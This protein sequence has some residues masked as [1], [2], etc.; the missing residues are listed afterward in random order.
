MKNDTTSRRVL[1]AGG[2]GYGNVGDEAQC[3]QILKELTERFPDCQIINLTPNIE[4][5]SKQHP[6]YQHELA[7]RTAFFKQNRKG[8]CFNFGTSF[9][10][11]CK[12]ILKSCW[13]YINAKLMQHK[14]PSILLDDDSVKLLRELKDASLFYFCGGGY[15]TGMTQSRL[16]DGALVCRLCHLFKTPVVMSGQTIGVWS[17]KWN[18]RIAKWGFKHVRVITARDEVHTLAA[19]K[20]IGLEGDS[21]F[22]T[23]DDAL[24]CEK[25]CDRQVA[26]QSYITLN[27]HYWGMS[28]EQRHLCIDKIHRL[29]EYVLTQT[30]DD[31]VF[32]P[33]VASDEQS[34]LDYIKKYPNERLSCFH[35]DYDFRK[36]RRVIADSNMCLTMKHHP[37]IFAMGEDCPA[38]SLAFSEYYVHKNVGALCQYKQ[39][40]FSVNMEQ[41][42]WFDDFAILFN[43][44]LSH[45]DEM[46]LLIKQQKQVLKQRKE[47]LSDVIVSILN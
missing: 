20:S 35:Y 7:S 25:S 46:K 12:F 27:F 3:N 42:S 5:S 13:V 34:Y 44:M 26:S 1:V 43:R 21:Y 30:S 37:I 22:A 24:F 32:I 39:E 38:L 18:Q 9:K 23:H 16:W 11:R 6:Q 15:L 45:S 31:L 28:G 8:D 41:E 29:V 33:M 40:D 36:V 14:L 10:R 2:Y 19:L 4:Y 17:G 47:K